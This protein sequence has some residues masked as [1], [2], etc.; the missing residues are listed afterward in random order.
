MKI[1]LT[2]GSGFVGAAVAEK[3]SPSHQIIALSR[4]EKS[5]AAIAAKGA[6]PVR[7]D[8]ES[9]AADMIAGCE[10]V[11]HCAAF[12]EEWGPLEAYERINVQGTERL[13]QMARAAGVKR[14]VH[15]GTEAALFH[16]QHMREIDETYPL[17]P[18]SPFPYSRT[19][20]RAEMAVIAANAPDAGFETIVIRPRLIWGEGDATVLPV[21]KAMAEEGKFAW[22]DGGKTET[23]TTHID[24]LVAAIELGLAKG[25]PGSAYFVVDGPPGPFREFLRP[26]L[27]TAGVDLPEKTVPGGVIRM[28]ANLTEPLWRLAGAKSPPPITRF[29]AHI[30]SRDCT[31]DDSKARAELGYRPVI[32]VDE[33]LRRLA[34]A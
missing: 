2:G 10:A 15:I 8:L 17:A 31:I 16:G 34:G 9:V 7:G 22:I 1:F 26:Y 21:V 3:L 32:S 4:S 5:D 11:I 30:M 14:F 25:N 28:F 13:L 6:R 24:N 12:V 18:N 27:A 20:A 29:T 33:G 23:S 19:K